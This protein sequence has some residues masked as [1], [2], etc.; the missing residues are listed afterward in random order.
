MEIQ[1]FNFAYF[2]WLIISVAI[3]AGLY[4]LLRNRCLK[5]QKIVL[6]SLFLF[7]LILHFLK[8]LIPPF[9]NDTEKWLNEAWPINICTANIF[10]FPFIYLSKSKWAKDYMFYIGVLSGLIAVLYPVEAL[11]KSNQMAEYLDIIRFYVHHIIIGVVPALMVM[12][13]HHTISYRS[14]FSAPIILLIVMLF[15]MVSQVIQSE[16]GYVSLRDEDFLDVNYKNSSY[17]WKPGKDGI[18]KVLSA[19]C[20]DFFK[21]VPVGTHAGQ[22]KYWPWFWMIFP[23]FIY[24]TPLSF[25]L[26]M[27]FDAKTLKRDVK[28]IYAFIK[29][30]IVK[31]LFFRHKNNI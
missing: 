23:V 10:L 14:V 21:T 16:L 4:F 19:V 3:L 31:K 28:T 17:I 26:S 6:F 30:R 13:K 5:T 2:F 8:V 24:V 9:S 12:L 15:I 18:G 25:A 29:E 7:A 27:I 1:L 11:E 20:P 22:P